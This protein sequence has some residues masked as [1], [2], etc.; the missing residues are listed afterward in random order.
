M[1]TSFDVLVVVLPILFGMA[2][3]IQMKNDEGVDILCALYSHRYKPSQGDPEGSE[4]DAERLAEFFCG[5]EKK[6]VYGEPP[7][8]GGDPMP[9]PSEE[10]EDAE[11][12]ADK[13]SS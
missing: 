3:G 11:D 5:K 8:L 2:E 7:E 1:G 9:Y 4:A 13:R 10:G 12:N 6:V